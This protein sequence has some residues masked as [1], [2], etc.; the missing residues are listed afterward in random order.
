MINYKI[1]KKVFSLVKRFGSV[2]GIIS[3]K[4]HLKG[5]VGFTGF[6]DLAFS[7]LKIYDMMCRKGLD[8]Y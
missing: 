5:A 7:S 1:T 8:L 4:H 2:D 6:L 3:I